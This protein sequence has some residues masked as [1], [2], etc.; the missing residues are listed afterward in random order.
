MKRTKP[1]HRIATVAPATRGW[2]VTLECGHT[3]HLYAY[4]SHL[5]F[6]EGCA[7]DTCDFV[8]MDLLHEQARYED[9]KRTTDAVLNRFIVSQFDP[10]NRYSRWYVT[11]RTLGFDV[12]AFDTQAE[13]QDRADALNTLEVI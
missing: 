8:V 9:A 2:H 5:A 7:C 10:L 12:A 11:D 6:A 3:R 4:P 13:A 1:Y